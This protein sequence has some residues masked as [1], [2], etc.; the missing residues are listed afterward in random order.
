MRVFS[1]VS[2]CSVFVRIGIVGP[3]AIGRRGAGVGL[4]VHDAAAKVNL[5]KME[6]LKYRMTGVRF[7]RTSW[8]G[9][10]SQCQLGHGDLASRTAFKGPRKEGGEC[11][12]SHANGSSSGRLGLTVLSGERHK[13]DETQKNDRTRDRSSRLQLLPS[14]AMRGA[15]EPVGRAGYRIEGMQRTRTRA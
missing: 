5:K 3:R 7:E 11:A 2:A 9:P 8:F 4:L 10:L 12:K 15:A 1:T 14:S 13:K 6:R